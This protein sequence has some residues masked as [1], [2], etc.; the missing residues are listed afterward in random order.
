LKEKIVSGCVDCHM[1]VQ[2]S[3]LI[4]SNSNGKQ[5]RAMVRSHW[6]KVYGD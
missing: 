4:I 3:N 1:P 6:I 2:A 5:T